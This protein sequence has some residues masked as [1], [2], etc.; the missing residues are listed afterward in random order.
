MFAGIK[1]GGSAVWIKAIHP[2][3]AEEDRFDLGVD[4]IE[5][6]GIQLHEIAHQAQQHGIL[7]HGGVEIGEGAKAMQPGQEKG[8]QL[9]LHLL[10][11]AGD[12]PIH[13]EINGG[14]G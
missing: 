5:L 2:G 1:E 12:E 4:L 13:R 11:G 6:A 9:E 10:R 3:P 14:D 8:F 7:A